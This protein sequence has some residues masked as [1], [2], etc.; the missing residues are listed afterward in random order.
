MKKMMK[1]VTRNKR[2]V[3]VSRFQGGNTQLQ[4]KISLYI[5]K[6]KSE[7]ESYDTPYLV[8]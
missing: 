3:A 2:S 6:A 8:P 5:L 4:T 7:L 1:T